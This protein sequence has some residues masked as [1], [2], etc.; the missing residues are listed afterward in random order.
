MWEKALQL[1]S[2]QN[3][4]NDNDFTAVKSQVLNSDLLW[5]THFQLIQDHITCFSVAKVCFFHVIFHLE[6]R[7]FSTQKKIFIYLVMNL[8][9]H[10]VISNNLSTF[11]WALLFLSG[12]FFRFFP[13]PF[14]KGCLQHQEDFIMSTWAF[15]IVAR[16]LILPKFYLSYYKTNTKP[17]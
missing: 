2:F 9:P 6:N 8:N 3:T 17:L 12:D 7:T 14:Q 13:M 11:Q 10:S 1:T 5:L 4:T 16:P 15:A